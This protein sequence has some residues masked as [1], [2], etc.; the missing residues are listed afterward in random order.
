MGSILSK[1][2]VKEIVFDL[3]TI[4]VNDM[5]QALNKKEN[6]SIFFFCLIKQ[7]KKITMFIWLAVNWDFRAFGTL[8]LPRFWPFMFSARNTGLNYVNFTIIY[9]QQQQSLKFVSGLFCSSVMAA[10]ASIIMSQFN[11]Y[12]WTL[13][14]N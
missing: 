1:I 13:L 4:E 2:F 5:L 3:L 12:S 7:K 14:W 8:N 10:F 9:V 11:G 6:R